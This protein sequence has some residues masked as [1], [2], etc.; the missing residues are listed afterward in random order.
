MACEMEVEYCSRN[1]LEFND[2]LRQKASSPTFSRE[3]IQK[4]QNVSP[5]KSQI[6]GICGCRSSN[7]LCCHWPMFAGSRHQSKELKRK[8]LIMTNTNQNANDEHRFRESFE[9]PSKVLMDDT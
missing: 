2:L 7:E 5:A 1:Y 4:S 3:G 6:N 9:L 8:Y